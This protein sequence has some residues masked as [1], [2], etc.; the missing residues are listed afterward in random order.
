MGEF[1]LEASF[2]YHPD[3]ITGKSFM[4]IINIDMKII[5]QFSSS[6]EALCF[7]TLL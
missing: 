5:V 2:E 7:K 1:I 4:P 3:F 6:I